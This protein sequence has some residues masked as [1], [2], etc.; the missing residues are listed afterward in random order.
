[1]KRFD[2]FTV[3]FSFNGKIHERLIHKGHSGVWVMKTMKGEH[4]VF[5]KIPHVKENMGWCMISEAQLPLEVLEQI[6]P[7]INLAHQ[8]YLANPEQNKRFR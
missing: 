4:V 3:Q 7:S 6:A 5:Q 1:M 8:R 2:E